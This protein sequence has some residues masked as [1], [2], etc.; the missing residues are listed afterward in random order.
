MGRRRNIDKASFNEVMLALLGSEA[1]LIP[2][3][4]AN[5]QAVGLPAS[6]TA[7]TTGATSMGTGS[8]TV[9]GPGNVRIYVVGALT[10]TNTSGPLI[11]GT[12]SLTQNG[13]NT[14]SLTGTALRGMPQVSM[15]NVSAANSEIVYEFFSNEVA[16]SGANTTIPWNPTVGQTIVATLSFTAS[17]TGASANASQVRLEMDE[18]F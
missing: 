5:H 3:V 10:A 18:S 15:Q 16:G 7:I 17:A 1:G 6:T 12:I 11:S 14:I 8:L 2:K 13:T 9:T 4:L